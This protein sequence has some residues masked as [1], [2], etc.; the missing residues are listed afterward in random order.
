M[1]GFFYQL[2]QGQNCHDG[3]PHDRGIKNQARNGY[4]KGPDEE[5]EIQRHT[6]LYRSDDDYQKK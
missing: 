6:V 4:L 1:K 5:F 2:R 3:S